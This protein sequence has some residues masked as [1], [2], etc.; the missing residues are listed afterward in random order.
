MRLPRFS[1]EPDLLEAAEPTGDTHQRHGQ[2]ENVGSLAWAAKWT[3]DVWNVSANSSS[4]VG[5]V[6][7]EGDATSAAM[8]RICTWTGWAVFEVPSKKKPYPSTPTRWFVGALR[9]QTVS[10]EPIG[11]VS[12]GRTLGGL[13]FLEFG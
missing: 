3:A 5:I 6:G 10:D 9:R 13:D 7:A 11:R 8:R 4:L 2:L 1:D 12:G